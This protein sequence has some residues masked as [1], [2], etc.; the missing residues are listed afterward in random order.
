MSPKHNSTSV[1]DR[2]ACRQLRNVMHV[3]CMRCRDYSLLPLPEGG[4]LNIKRAL[5]SSTFFRIST[6]HLRII[7]KMSGQASERLANIKNII[8]P[9]D[10]DSEDYPERPFRVCVIGS[11]NWGTTIA[12]VVSENCAERTQEFEE[13]VKVWVFEEQ[14]NGRNLTEIINEDHENVKYL[15]GVKLPHNLVADPN[16]IHV[17]EDADLIV[18]NIP[19]QFLHNIVKQIKGKVQ[20][21]AR[22]ISC[23]KGLDVTPDGCKL[24]TDYITRHLGIACGALS[25]AN[26]APEVAREKWSETS[27]GYLLPEDFQGKGKDIDQTTLKHVFHRPYFHVRVI[28]DVAGV[29]LAGALKN[30]VAVAAGMVEGLGWGDNAKAAI[31]RIGIMEMTKFAHQFFPEA[32]SDT[33]SVESAGVADL[34]TTCSGGRNVRV[35]KFMAETGKSAEVA[36]KELL[37]G[38][39][40]QGVITAKEVHELLEN[41]GDVSEYP[42]FESTFQILYGDAKMENLPKLLEDFGDN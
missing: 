11:G 3:S 26:L 5:I 7:P 32:N 22:A 13:I 34:I 27:V 30:I 16:L 31:M 40:A 19:H 9:S 17:V 23:L 4:E 18:F 21:H 37:N 12:K 28:D 24:L 25:G 35:G 39:S 42:L 1:S 29:S 38:Q 14:V 33:F 2:T 6:K 36:E 8:S 15:P 10:S 20:P 41:K